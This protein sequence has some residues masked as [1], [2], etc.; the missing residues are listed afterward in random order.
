MK[1]MLRQKEEGKG[2]WGRMGWGWEREGDGGREDTE[3]FKGDLLLALWHVKWR[4]NKDGEDIISNIKSYILKFKI[5][6]FH[7]GPVLL[8]LNTHTHTHNSTN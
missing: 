6:Y 5:M 4:R 3:I 7:Y 1:Q 2:G 8:N